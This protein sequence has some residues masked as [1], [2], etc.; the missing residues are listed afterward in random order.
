MRISVP[1][2][3]GAALAIWGAVTAFGACAETRQAVPTADHVVMVVM[4]NRSYGEIIDGGKAP[5]IAQ[6]AERGANFTNAFAVAHPSQ[7]NY[8]ALFSGSTHGVTDNRAH[9]FSAPTLAGAL[10]AAGKSFIG[11]VE[12]GSPRKHNPWE[13]FADAQG[14]GRDFSE[15][16]G[17][18]G[19]LPAVSFVIPNLD[20]DMHDGSIGD[21]DG[22]LRQHLGAYAAWCME[23]NN[24]LIVTF[25]EDDGG[26]GNRIATVFFGGKVMPGRYGQR[27]DHYRVLRT[28]EAMHALPPLGHSAEEAPIGDIWKPGS[29]LDAPR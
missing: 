22:W 7:P 24:L 21:G 18:F 1:R 8:F 12:R 29:E 14:V 6:L 23:G 15:F 5:F 19:T 27:I 28:L 25:D 4:E 9:A 17:D 2:C 16:P 26:A 20:H 10:R 3:A 13:S 11:Y